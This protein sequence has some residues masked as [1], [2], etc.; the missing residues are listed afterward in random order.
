VAAAA[1]AG[2]LGWQRLAV[3]PAAVTLVSAL[4]A[5][6]VLRRLSLMLKQL[7]ANRPINA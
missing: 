1:A 2:V 3:V 7:D 4:G 5:G 6:D